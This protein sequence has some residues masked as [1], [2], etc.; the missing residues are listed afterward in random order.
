VDQLLSKSEDASLDRIR[1]DAKYRIA[2]WNA[3]P[4][5]KE[6]QRIDHLIKYIMNRPV[7]SIE[8][9]RE[10]WLGI[11]TKSEKCRNAMKRLYDISSVAKDIDADWSARAKKDEA[12]YNKWE[13]ICVFIDRCIQA[14]K[15]TDLLAFAQSEYRKTYDK[16]FC[17]Q[18]CQQCGSWPKY[19]R[20]SVAVYFATRL[21]FERHEILSRV[22]QNKIGA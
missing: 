14:N 13:T 7:E 4:L 12:R 19:I 21:A 5:R 6:A 11:L 9:K 1:Y 3:E 18:L 10:K 8:W 20:S 22:L 2:C 17:V 15:D 16:M